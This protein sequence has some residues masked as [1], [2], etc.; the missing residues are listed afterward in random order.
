MQQ[1]DLPFGSEFSPSQID[2]AQLL[3]LAKQNSG[4]WRIFEETIRE[5]Y[6]DRNNTN[7]TNKKK[8]A[9]NTKLGMIAYGLI[10][11]DVNFTELGD[12]LFSIKADKTKLYEELARHI[13]LNLHGMTFVQCILDIQSAGETVDL[14]KLREWLE[15]RG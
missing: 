15:Q 3:E 8:L 11:R 14:I 5:T 12:Y 7:D 9:N 6:F 13:L 10:D 2:L 4:N 1:S